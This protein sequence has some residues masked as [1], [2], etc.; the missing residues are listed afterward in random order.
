VLAIDG[1]Q[2]FNKSSDEIV[3]LI[4]GPIGSWV[5]IALYRQQGRPASTTSSNSIFSNATHVTHHEVS[6]STVDL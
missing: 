2:V 6:P 4:K 3:N 1:I 5:A